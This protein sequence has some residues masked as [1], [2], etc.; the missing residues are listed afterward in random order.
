MDAAE[1]VV[2]SFDTTWAARGSTLRGL[3]E[4]GHAATFAGRCR[5][6]RRMARALWEKT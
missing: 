6:L 1:L 5:G 4:W 2:E 3:L